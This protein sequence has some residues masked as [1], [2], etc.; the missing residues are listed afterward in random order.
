MEVFDGSHGM[1]CDALATFSASGWAVHGPTWQ[2]K[3]LC[4]SF[5]GP[6]AHSFDRTPF[7][8]LPTR[9]LTQNQQNCE[10]NKKLWERFRQR[11]SLFAVGELN[12][13]ALLHVPCS[14]PSRLPD[15]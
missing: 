14:L 1:P 5:H 4:L 3:V 2:G 13:N 15:A 10:N 12:A 7:L 6:F 11:L 8:V 9:M